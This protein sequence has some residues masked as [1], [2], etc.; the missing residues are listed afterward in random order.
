MTLRTLRILAAAGMIGWMV[1]GLVI[2]RVLWPALIGDFAVALGIARG[3][4]TTHLLWGVLLVAGG[5]A[6]Y[7]SRYPELIETEGRPYLA[8]LAA[9]VCTGAIGIAVGSPT[10]AAGAVLLF[11]AVA[12][13]WLRHSHSLK[14]ERRIGSAVTPVIVHESHERI[15]AVLGGRHL[16]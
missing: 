5:L 10:L 13:L 1:L 8:A 15:R 7:F 6:A 12:W 2:L 16:V 9:L 3:L 11:A 4:F 14:R